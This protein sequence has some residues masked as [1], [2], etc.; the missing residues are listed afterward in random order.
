MHH[1]LSAHKMFPSWRFFLTAEI[2]ALSYQSDTDKTKKK[3]KKKKKK[4]GERERETENDRRITERT[5]AYLLFLIFRCEQIDINEINT[6]RI[7]FMR[8]Y[9]RTAI[10]RRANC[11]RLSACDKWNA[12]F[13]VM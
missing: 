8:T 6:N 11:G 2:R 5:R 4:K 10:F 12:K 9:A 3:K 1:Y 13:A 7:V